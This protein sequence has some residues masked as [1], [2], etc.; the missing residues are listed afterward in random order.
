MTTKT[1][2]K[3][4]DC[5]EMKNRIQAQMFEQY[6]ARKSEFASFRDFAVAQAEASDWA[7]Q[8]RERFRG[9]QR[10]AEGAKP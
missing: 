6:C 3:A 4:F 5:V 9:Q 8:M 7:R 1:K 10:A 2:T